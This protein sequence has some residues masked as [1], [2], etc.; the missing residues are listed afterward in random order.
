[1]NAGINKVPDPSVFVA[2][3]N[4]NRIFDDIIHLCEPLGEQTKEAIK[5]ASFDASA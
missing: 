1:M 5:L 2:L 4:I 3:N